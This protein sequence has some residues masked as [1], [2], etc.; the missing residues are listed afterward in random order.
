[1]AMR[2][3]SHKCY[4]NVGGTDVCWSGPRSWSGCGYGCRVGVWVWVW[5][6]GVGVRVSLNGMAMW[7]MRGTAEGADAFKVCV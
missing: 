1:M 5:V 4:G 7:S 3:P 2:I 6:W